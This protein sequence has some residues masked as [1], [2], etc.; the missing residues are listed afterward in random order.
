M[1]W[2]NGQSESPFPPVTVSP[3]LLVLLQ[4]QSLGIY[5]AQV[6]VDICPVVPRRTVAVSRDDPRSLH[7]RS[8]DALRLFVPRTCTETAKRA[9]NVAA[10]NVWNSL[11]ID[12]HNTNCLSTFR[13][14]LKT[15]FFLKQLIHD[16]TYPLH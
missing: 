11:P 2:H 9:F 8:I 3:L 7:V 12:I 16:E 10:H 5:N 6:F 13:N 1:P 4:F 14:K 15:V